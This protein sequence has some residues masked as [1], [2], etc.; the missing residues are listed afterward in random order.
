ML[1]GF[2]QFIMRGNV[3]DLAVGIVIGG[4]FAGVVSA[5]TDGLLTPLIAAVF[6]EASLAGVGNF[7]LNGAQFSIGLFLDAVLRFLLVAAA[8]YAVVVLPMNR[9]AERRARGQEP[10]PEPVPSPDVVLLT[11]IRDLLAERR[12]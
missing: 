10:E 7:T 12:A 8:L 3:V 11:E 5:L 6:G 4:A 2:K 1:S 9:L